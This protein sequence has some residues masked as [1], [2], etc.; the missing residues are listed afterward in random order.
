[1][2]WLLRRGLAKLGARTIVGI[3]AT[4]LVL[5]VLIPDPIPF[6]DETLLLIGTVLLSRWAK[7]RETTGDAASLKYAGR[8]RTPSP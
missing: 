8:G 6:L 5:D 2:R 4:L 1:M 3:A 7:G